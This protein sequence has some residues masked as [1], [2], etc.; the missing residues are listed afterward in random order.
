MRRAI[1]QVV[2]AFE[3]PVTPTVEQVFTSAYLPPA[4]ARRLD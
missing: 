3:L 4:A 1:A 2:Q